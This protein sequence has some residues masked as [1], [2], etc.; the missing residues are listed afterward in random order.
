MTTLTLEQEQ[1][2]EALAARVQA[3][4]AAGSDLLKTWTG[5][6]L[7]EASRFVDGLL[8]RKAALEGRLLGW[9]EQQP[10][11]APFAFLA[12]CSL[13]FYSAEKETNPKIKTY[14]DAFYYISTCA[15]VGYADVFAVTQKGRAIA[16]LVMIVGPALTSHALERPLK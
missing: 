8:A 7:E 15:S 16:S 5:I 11:E 12:A 9:V 1:A 2:L 3:G 6:S 4:H 13:A 14:V 10:L